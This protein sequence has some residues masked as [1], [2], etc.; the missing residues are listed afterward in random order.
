MINS[1]YSRKLKRNK[2]NTIYSISKMPM[3]YQ[4]NKQNALNYAKKNPDKIRAI[5]RKSR[6][7]RN[8]FKKISKIFYNI[9][10]D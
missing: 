7:K 5:N 2:A 9:L 1:L 6:N 4:Q 10:L 8:E 3:T